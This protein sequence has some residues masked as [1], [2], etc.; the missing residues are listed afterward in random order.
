MLWQGVLTWQ[1]QWAAALAGARQIAMSVQL[2]GA[3][4]ICCSAGL[5]AAMHWQLRR[6]AGAWAI[7][8]STEWRLPA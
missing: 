3:C 8:A 7:K 2:Y 5:A 4:Y 6:C 1:R